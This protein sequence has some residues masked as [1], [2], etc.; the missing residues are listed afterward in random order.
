[1]RKVLRSEELF[2]AQTQAKARGSHLVLYAKSRLAAAKCQ[3]LDPFVDALVERWPKV[4]WLV[5]D[6]IDLAAAA[7]K[8]GFSGEKPEFVYFGPEQSQEDEAKVDTIRDPTSTQLLHWAVPRLR[9][10]AAS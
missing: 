8:F 7:T 9:S 2:R 5:L 6:P 3:E 10:S 4:N 1:M